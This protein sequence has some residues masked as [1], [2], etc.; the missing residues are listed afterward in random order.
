MQLTDT[1]SI[2]EKRSSWSPNDDKIIFVRWDWVDRDLYTITSTG[3]DYQL[4]LE[5]PEDQNFPHW[6]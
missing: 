1:E 6:R 5:L 3:A 4:F 2:D